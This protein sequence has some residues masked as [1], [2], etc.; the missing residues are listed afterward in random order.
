M[1]ARGWWGKSS[2]RGFLWWILLFHWLR[3]VTFF[4]MWSV[5][6]SERLA[7][8]TH[9]CTRTLFAG[10]VSY[11]VSSKNAFRFVPGDI[12]APS[13]PSSLWT[14]SLSV[15]P[16]FAISCSSWSRENYQSYTMDSFIFLY[17]LPLSAIPTH[18][19]PLLILRSSPALLCL[20]TKGPVMPPNQG[21]EV[22]IYNR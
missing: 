3:R 13:F 7:V 14:P 11:L 20:L 15:L 22:I 12:G 6:K 17:S 16:F 19:C 4:C 2:C 10:S 8:I 5:K 21:R 1:L 9:R 18:S